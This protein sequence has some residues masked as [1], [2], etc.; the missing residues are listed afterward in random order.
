MQPIATPPIADTI[1]RAFQGD[2]QPWRGALCE[3]R[4]RVWVVRGITTY[5]IYERSMTCRSS[6][7]NS[8]RRARGGLG[9][10]KARGVVLCRRLLSQCRIELFALGLAAAAWPRFA[11]RNAHLTQVVLRLHWTDSSSERGFWGDRNASIP[12]MTAWPVLRVRVGRCQ[13]HCSD[14]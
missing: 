9:R 6:V 7:E 12:T 11:H 4:A 14:Q 13:G 1:G 8:V 3:L 10:P 5:V 2:I